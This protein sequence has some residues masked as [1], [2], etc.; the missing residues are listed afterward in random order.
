M[1]LTI[2]VNSSFASIPKSTLAV[3]F[4]AMWLQI[5][6]NKLTHTPHAML[7]WS[8]SLRLTVVQGTTTSCEI[9]KKQS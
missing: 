3:K 4:R 2:E 5:T 9:F 7:P 1:T 8:C 6:L